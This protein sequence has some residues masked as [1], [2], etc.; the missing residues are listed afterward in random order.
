MEVI[1]KPVAIHPFHKEHKGQRVEERQVTEE[2]VKEDYSVFSEEDAATLRSIILSLEQS[3]RV[4]KTKHLCTGQVLLP[5][6]LLALIALDIMRMSDGEICGLRG[7]LIK[8]NFAAST[9]ET[10]EIGQ[11]RCDPSIPFTFQLQLILEEEDH[12]WFYEKLPQI[13]K[14]WAK[15]PII[16]SNRYTLAKKKLYR[17]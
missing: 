15:G 14:S 3:L 7:A 5:P 12:G 11:I 10:M 4:A 8:I 13:L 2:R 6:N 9:K 17:R 16:L 1:R